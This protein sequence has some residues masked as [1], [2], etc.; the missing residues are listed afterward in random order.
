M[1]LKGKRV[2]VLALQGAFNEHLS[3][4]RRLKIEG[5]E[6][7]RAAD[8]EG[9]SG[10]IIPGGESTSMGRL[11]ADTG[12]RGPLLQ[13]AAAGMAIM[14]TCA[15]MILLARH[16][17][18]Y[19]F[20]PLGLMDITVRRNA[21]GRQVDSFE[22]AV[23]IPALGPAPFPAVFIRAPFIEKIGPGVEALARLEDSRIVAARQGKFLALAFHPELTRD[24]R[25]HAFF[26]RMLE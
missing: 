19:P 17:T 1:A 23:A 13:R 2:G 10:L 6:V 11:M 20:E 3:V 5:V 12:L 16:A 7:R 18:D 9:L 4:L 21:F 24:L 25:C 22:A 26:T 8:L 14:G 15:G